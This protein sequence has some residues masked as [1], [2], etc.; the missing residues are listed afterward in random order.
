MLLRSLS[1]STFPVAG[2][3]FLSLFFVVRMDYS[4]DDSR[5]ERVREKRDE[6][7]VITSKNMII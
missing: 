6:N 2:K 5:K 3:S 7:L 1:S 4:V